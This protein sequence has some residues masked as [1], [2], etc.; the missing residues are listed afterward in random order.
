MTTAVYIYLAYTITSIGMT[1]W[2]ARTLH[3]NGRVFLVDAFRGKEEMADSVNHLLVV[4]FYLINIG[5]ILLFLRFGTPPETLVN[6]IEYI[7]TKLG[8]VL[9]VLG[10]MHFFNM[11]NFHRM[12]KK[13][14][15]HESSPP[16]PSA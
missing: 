15:H 14:T 1:I 4:G 11:F 6:G 12:R 8:V 13:G 3:K 16:A 10:A 5:F 9:L 2:V 7:A